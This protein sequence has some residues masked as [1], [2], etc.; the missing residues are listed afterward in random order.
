MKSNLE[1]EVWTMAL[2]SKY[3][4]V[5]NMG[6]VR[7]LTHVVK[8]GPAPGIRRV[9]GITLKPF[10]NTATGYLQVV[11]ADRKKHSVH[12]LV[13]YAFC[14][15]YATGLVVNHK[16]GIKTDNR[17]SNLEWVTQAKNNQHA[18][19]SLRRKGSGTGKF[20][21]EHQAS[22]AIV[23]TSIADGSKEFFGCAL[24]AVRKYP[25]LDSGAISRCCSGN[26]KSHKGYQFGF[27]A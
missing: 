23:M 19:S 25:T 22:K 2:G 3:H 20:G 26:S 8:C 18:Y 10:I 4:E 1:I 27:S 11:F 21:A 14:K 9:G 17:A 16:N 24:D 6:G 15:G 13:A 7:S 5:S 12:R